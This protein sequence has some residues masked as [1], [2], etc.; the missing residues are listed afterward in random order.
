MPLTDKRALVIG[1]GPAGLM[2]A[3][4]LASAGVSV[5][6]YDAMPSVG[7]K[8]LR[9]GI[10]GLNITHSEDSE[11]FL[12]RFTGRE[13]QVAR[14]LAEFD[15]MAL[16]RW[17]AELGVETFVGSSGRVFPVEKKAAPLLRRWLARLRA[18]GVSFHTR[19]RFCCWDNSD[20][21][22]EHG[23]SVVNVRADVAV[24][25]TG[26]GSWSALGSD[27]RWL[28]LFRE[29]GI[30]CADFRPSNCGFDYAWPLALVGEHI[31]SPLKNIGLAI[32]GNS[33]QQWY[34]RGDALLS[35]YGVE[36][37][38]IYAA[39]ADMRDH[40]D[41]DGVV[42][43]Y[44]DL[45]PDCSPGKIA[46]VLAARKAKESLSNSLRKLGVKGAKL[47]LLKALS[48][49][50]QMQDLAG[51]PELLK[52]LPQGFHSYRPV[53][54]A[55]STAGG[56]CFSCVDEGMMIKGLP[57]NFCAGEMLDWEAPTG[58]YLLTACFASG[59]VA[60]RGAV[61]YLNSLP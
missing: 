29:K 34:R 52:R 14:L 59:V 11:Q 32:E 37:S 6:V 40:I 44:W 10:G 48:S 43:V 25:A 23:E 3:E 50:E 13:V 4:Q 57:G 39:S 9:A 26:G 20:Y 27:G 33:G 18:A 47:A 49:R 31:G 42:T 5:A 1:G 35:Q 24:F 41:A 21:R 8:F 7:R 58:G 28:S 53:D 12:S 30:S 22:F 46:Q 55:I 60:G 61:A 19:H 16:R 15:S 36:G 45:L 2:A 51:L 38:L 54:E 17:C 56:V